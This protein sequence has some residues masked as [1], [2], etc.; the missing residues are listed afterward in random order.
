MRLARNTITARFT[1]P[2]VSRTKA[3]ASFAIAVASKT[4]TTRAMAAPVPRMPHVGVWKRLKRPKKVG[5]SPSRLIA[6]GYRAAARMPALAAEENAASA[7]TTTRTA[8][9]A[10]RTASAAV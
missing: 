1:S 3:L 9:A 7:A 2:R 10:G 8:P 5:N 4:A 6:S